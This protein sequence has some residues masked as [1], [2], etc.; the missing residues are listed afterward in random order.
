VIEADVEGLALGLALAFTDGLAVALGLG[1]ALAVADDLALAVAVGSLGV[2]D[3]GTGVGDGM[4]PMLAAVVGSGDCGAFELG[5][6][7]V[8]ETGASDAGAL[9]AGVAFAV[10]FEWATRDIATDPM[11]SAAT[12]AAAAR[13]VTIPRPRLADPTAFS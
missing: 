6:A 11:I 9:A 7:R 2:A 13:T 10:A 8:D 12:P 4:G 3:N 1:L 5:T